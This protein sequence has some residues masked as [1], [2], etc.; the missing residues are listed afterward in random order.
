[1]IPGAAVEEI[2]DTAALARLEGAWWDLWHRSPTATPFQSPA[3][4]LPWWQA[5]APGSLMVIAVRDGRRLTALAPLYLEDGPLGRRLL[6]L[7]ISLSDYLD[8][9]VDPAAPA[10]GDAIAHHLARRHADWDLIELSDLPP[11]A[12]ALTLPCPQR[13]TDTIRATEACPILHLGSDSVDAGNAPTIPA[14]QRRKLRMA[15]HRMERSAATSIIAT[16]ALTPAAW[17]DA[18]SRLH[19]ARWQERGEAGVLRDDCVQVFHRKALAALCEHRIARLFGIV[20]GSDL[21]GAY[22]GFH[23]RDRAYAYLGGFDPRFAYYSPGT[24]L[25]G[26]AIEDAARNG[27]REF[28][29]LRGGEAYKYAWGAADRRNLRRTFVKNGDA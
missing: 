4:L 20:I 3:W 24:I 21:A 10:A 6:P 2:N 28:H 11:G 19:T 29:F 8:I 17:I 5:F 7:G 18:L 12:A 9:L 1:M 25:I 13:T 26:H 23:H 14:R 16:H 27:A 22:Y 15:R